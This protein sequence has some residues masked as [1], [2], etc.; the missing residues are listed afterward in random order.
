MMIIV[1]DKKCFILYLIKRNNA[2]FI[3]AVVLTKAENKHF[4]YFIDIFQMYMFVAN[5]YR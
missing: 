3:L 4:I 2:F 1:N 5:L